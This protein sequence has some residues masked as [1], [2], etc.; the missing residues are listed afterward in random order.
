MHAI[1]NDLRLEYVIAVE[2]VVRPR[3]SESVNTK[4][5]TGMIEVTAIFSYL[6]T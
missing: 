1:V 6:D 3:P 5:N 2:G 4:M